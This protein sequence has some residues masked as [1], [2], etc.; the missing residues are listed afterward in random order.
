ML[1]VYARFVRIRAVFF[2][3]VWISL[4][5]KNLTCSQSPMIFFRNFHAAL[6]VQIAWILNSRNV[7]CLRK[8]MKVRALETDNITFNKWKQVN[9]RAQKV[10]VSIDMKEVSPR[11]NTHVKTLKHHIHVKRIQHATFYN[12]KSNLKERREILI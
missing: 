1:H 8:L 3:R 10:S 11:F 6:T 5:L 12:L 4:F 7:N 9:C 2:S